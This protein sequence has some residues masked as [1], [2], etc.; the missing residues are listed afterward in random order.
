MSGF[1]SPPH[2]TSAAATTT[3]P[4]TFFTCFLRSET[5]VFFRHERCREIGSGQDAGLVG[6]RLLRRFRGAPHP[7]ALLHRRGDHRA[8][9]A[10]QSPDVQRGGGGAPAGHAPAPCRAPLFPAPP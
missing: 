6:R 2:A 10:L 5:C 8:A 7:L 3:N 4:M 9:L 1:F